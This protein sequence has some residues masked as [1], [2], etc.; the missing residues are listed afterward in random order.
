[1]NK[2][3]QR[4]RGQE[5]KEKGKKRNESVIIEEKGNSEQKGRGEKNVNE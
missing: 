5:K 3:A 1:M 4:E 2:D